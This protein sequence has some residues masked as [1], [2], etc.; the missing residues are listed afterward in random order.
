MLESASAIAREHCTYL[1]NA[2]YKAYE[3]WYMHGRTPPPLNYATWAAARAF[4]AREWEILG[5]RV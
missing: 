5:M 2:G 1:F 4:I 3:V